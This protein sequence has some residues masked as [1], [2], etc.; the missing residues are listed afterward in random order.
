MRIIGVI[1]AATVGIGLLAGCGSPAPAPSAPVTPPPASEP[2]PAP[3]ET[4]PTAPAGE[5]SIDDFLQRV[6]AAEM[7]TYTMEMGVSTTVEGTPMEIATSGSFDNSDPAN[8]SSQMK[9][10]LGGME[11]EIILVDGDAYLK[12]AMLGDQWMRMDPKDAAEIAGSSGPDLGQWTKDYAKNVEK[13]E[14]IGEDTTNG[15]ATTQYRLTLK[16]ESLGDLG[17]SEAGIEATDVVF[18][19]WIDGE[20]FT[21]KFAMDMKGDVPIAMTATLDNINQPVSIE[22]PKDWVEMPS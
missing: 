18:D 3:S 6:S 14:L 20:G 2:A 21:R 15:V 16:P 19:V 9:M 7:K 17:M 8:P 13:V 5:V 4:V 1:A 11:M 10:D 12:M 22:A